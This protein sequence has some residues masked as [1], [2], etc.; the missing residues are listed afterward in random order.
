MVQLTICVVAALFSVQDRD[1]EKKLCFHF[2]EASVEAVL[3]YV[4]SVTGWIIIQEKTVAGTITAFS[5]AEV[6]ASKCLEFL[7]AA[8][9]PVDAIIT[10]PCAPDTPKPGQVLRVQDLNEALRRNLRIFQGCD[11]DAIP[12]SPDLRTQIVPL[13][14]LNAA[15]VQKEFAELLKKIL[16]ADGQI[17]VSTHS[18]ALVLSGRS[19]CIRNAV[20]LLRM[21]DVSTSGELRMQTFTLKNADAGEAARTLNEVYNPNE[22]MKSQQAMIAAQMG[23]A[24]KGAS[25]RPLSRETIRVVPETQTNSVIVIANEENLA[26]I[27]RMV[28]RLDQRGSATVKVKFYTLRYSDA[29]A[30]AKFVNDLFSDTSGPRAPQGSRGGRGQLFVYDVY[31]RMVPQNDS[32]GS[33]LEVRVIA[34]PR[35][36]KLVVAASEQR[37]VMIDAIVEELDQPVNDLVQLRI[38]KLRHASAVETAAILKDLFFAQVKATQ[39][40]GGRQGNQTAPPAPPQPGVGSVPPQG[41]KGQAEGMALLPSQEMEITADPRTSRV[42]VRAS[43]EYLAIMDQVVQELD[44]DPTASVSTY[45]VQLRNGDAAG[46][47]T[48]LQNLLR[49]T[50]LASQIAAPPPSQQQPNASPSTYG[51]T[52]RPGLQGSRTQGM[53]T[54]TP[55]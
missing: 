19:D 11:P 25:A 17:A 52:N 15:E 12:I 32:S 48:V 21:I 36:N 29:L 38:Y 46:L 54:G 28:E 41:G 6:P 18:N 55:R 2:K 53:G 14:A 47:A 20:R 37:L 1:A 39:N 33:A 24:Q 23:Q 30:V 27:R 43:K 3:K 7:N 45:V 26:D 34:D 13:K 8:L 4:S 31:G 9:R 42:I 22:A 51:S 10:N 5:D 44:A 49:G 16:E 40:S 35:A 50:P